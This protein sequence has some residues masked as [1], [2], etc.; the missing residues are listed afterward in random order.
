MHVIKTNYDLYRIYSFG[1]FCQAHLIPDKPALVWAVY[2][3][4]L[5]DLNSYN[6]VLVKFSL[7]TLSHFINTLCVQKGAK[8]FIVYPSPCL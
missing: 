2:P 8:G 1:W 7:S 4:I 6:Q 3:D 5:L